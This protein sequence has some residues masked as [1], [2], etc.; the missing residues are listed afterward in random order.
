MAR[1]DLPTIF[2]LGHL[3]LP[4]AQSNCSWM[5]LLFMYIHWVHWYYILLVF[6]LQYLSYH[7]DVWHLFILPL[8]CRSCWRFN[9]CLYTCKWES[10]GRASLLANLRNGAT[11]HIFH[12]QHYVFLSIVNFN[13]LCIVFYQIGRI[14]FN[15]V[16]YVDI[17]L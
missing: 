8:S 17:Y 13:V 9:D 15:L 14:F 2:F 4:I 5:S 3:H 1:L 7:P 11:L 12:I 16:Y 10:N 6:S